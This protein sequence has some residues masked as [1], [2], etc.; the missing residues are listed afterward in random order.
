ML[1]GSLSLPA[2]PSISSRHTVASTKN[3]IMSQVSGALC[4]RDVPQTIRNIDFLEVSGGPLDPGR[5]LWAL[6]R[7]RCMKAR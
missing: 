3:G 2:T 6:S 4:P 7:T 5:K 1:G